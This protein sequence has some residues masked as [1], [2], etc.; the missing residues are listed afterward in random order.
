[1]LYL[2]HIASEQGVM[3]DPGKCTKVVNWPILSCLVEFQGFLGLANYYRH[4][5]HGLLELL[6][7]CMSCVGKEVILNSLWTA[8]RLLQN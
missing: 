2:G 5:I 4:F 6:S 3:P 8:K 7:L 1:M